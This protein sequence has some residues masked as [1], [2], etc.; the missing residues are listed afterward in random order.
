MSLFHRA[1]NVPHHVRRAHRRL[2]GLPALIII[3]GVI[4]GA[5]M[6]AYLLRQNNLGMVEL[7]RE[8]VRADA[9]GDKA[10]TEQ[11]LQALQSYVARHMHTSTSVDLSASYQR[12]VVRV[13]KS[14]AS[15]LGNINLYNR[16]EAVCRREDRGSGVE[17]AECITKKLSGE[18]GGVIP[19]PSPALYRYTFAAPTLSLDLAGFTLLISSLFAYAGLYQLVRYL[20][21]RYFPLKK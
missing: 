20:V 14:T 17:L 8:V 21:P 13:Q 9:T 2:V 16:A 6:S 7:R 19:L 15:R 11:S 5:A 10:T 3:I 18:S 12:E 1:K 4:A